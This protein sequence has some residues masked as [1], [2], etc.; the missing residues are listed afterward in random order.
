[1]YPMAKK[2]GHRRDWHGL[3]SRPRQTGFTADIA[4]DNFHIEAPMRPCLSGRRPG[5]S[6]IT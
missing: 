4:G 6:E 5:L 3:A 2:N 1:M